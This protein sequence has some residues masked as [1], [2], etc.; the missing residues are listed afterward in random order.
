MCL[1]ASVL[2]QDHFKGQQLDLTCAEMHLVII[3][4]PPDYVDVLKAFVP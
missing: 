3:L 2:L 4:F 1:W